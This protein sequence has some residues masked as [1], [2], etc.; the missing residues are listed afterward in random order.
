MFSRLFLL[1]V[2]LAMFLANPATAALSKSD[3]ILRKAWTQ[4]R[5]EFQANF[6]GK[7]DRVLSD[8]TV[9]DKHQRFIVRLATGQTLLIAH[10]IDLAPRIP[11]PKAGMAVK[12]RGEYIWNAQGGILHFTHRASYPGHPDGWL[13]YRGRKY[14]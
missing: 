1:P 6:S 14:W 3:K 5:T 2:L 8:D 4:Q 13:I 10:N 12:G 9:G 11:S 7:I